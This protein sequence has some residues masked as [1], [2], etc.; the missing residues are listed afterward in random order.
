MVKVKVADGYLG[1]RGVFLCVVSLLLFVS[2]VPGWSSAVPA[3]IAVPD[4]SAMLH[5]RRLDKVTK[6]AAGRKAQAMRTSGYYSELSAGTMQR[7]GLSDVSDAMNHMAGVTLRDYGGAG[8][9]KTASVRGLGASHTA[10][11]YDGIMLSDV[12]TGQIDLNRFSLRDVTSVGLVAGDGFS[13]LDPARAAAAAA[14]VN[15]ETGGALPGDKGAVLRLE[16]GSFGRLGALARWKG[17]SRQGHV[18]SATA[19]WLMAENDYPYTLRN[20]LTSTR[21]HR[22]N[23][24]MN[25]WRAEVNTALHLG[26]HS[27]VDAKV[28][29]YD[30]NH[31]LPGA[32]VFYN[33]IN[34]EKQHDR[35]LLG[36]ARWLNRFNEAWTLQ[37]LG[38]Y[39]WTESRYSDKSNEYTGGVLQE[40][41][42]QREWYASALLRFKPDAH[43]GASYAADYIYNN[44]NSNLNNGMHASRHSVLQSLTL[45]YNAGPLALSGRMLCSAFFNEAVGQQAADDVCRFTPSLSATYRLWKTLRLRAFYKDIFR[46]PTFTESYYYHLGSANLLPE[47][48]HQLGGGLVFDKTP[49]NGFPSLM[50]A[51]DVYK[52][53][54]MDKIVSVPVNLHTWRTINLGRV[55]VLGLDVTAE[56]R[57]QIKTDHIVGIHANITHQSAEDCTQHS[58]ITYG[59]QLAYT[60]EW[61]G[62]AA[63]SYENPWVNIAVNATGTSSRYAT[64]EH[65]D[66]TRL[67]AY[68]E[69]GCSAWRNFQ[70]CG[71]SC[72]VRADVQ[73]L[74]DKQYDVVAGYPMPGCSYCISLKFHF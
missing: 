27:R 1:R 74:F 57:Y 73:N 45:N 9:I 47:R 65:S 3:I 51:V 59:K 24:R 44:L 70:I 56:S 49:T 21:E 2:S 72:E 4:D 71:A 10:V 14:T 43:W 34:H 61:V 40:N 33:P 18:L 8:G 41:Y 64:H 20:G 46:V 29:Y 54:V 42:W 53:R 62:A 13:L 30:I 25:A 37:M 39:S 66:G 12:Q 19:D 11:A 5:V 7:M 6:R 55:D 17:V 69:F 31:R 22:D 16:Q 67:P 28:Y 52:N 38:K 60:P 63:V 15:I 50:L 58:S 36:Q 26:E 48:T 68:A 35:N 23:S 32:V